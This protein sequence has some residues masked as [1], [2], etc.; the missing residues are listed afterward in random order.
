MGH[1][2]DGFLVHTVWMEPASERQRMENL[3]EAYP[4]DPRLIPVFDRTGRSNIGYALETAVL[5][6]LERRRT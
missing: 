1:L 3:R 5:L 4:V 2:Q 6:K